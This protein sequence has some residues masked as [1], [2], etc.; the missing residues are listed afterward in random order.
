[1]PEKTASWWGVGGVEGR[2]TKDRSYKYKTSL[3]DD[4]HKFSV[5]R[6]SV[7]GSFHQG[8]A[9]KKSL[10]FSATFFS[11]K[12]PTLMPVPWGVFMG[13]KV[14]SWGKHS[15]GGALMKQIAVQ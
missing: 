14:K 5:I 7:Q 3:L 8:W 11:L 10:N 9:F 2:K 12:D 1:M 4:N 13:A 6:I 15:G